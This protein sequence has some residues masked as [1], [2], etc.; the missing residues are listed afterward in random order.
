MIVAYTWFSRTRETM[1][2]DDIKQ[3][4]RTIEYRNIVKYN[5]INIQI[6]IILTSITPVLKSRTIVIFESPCFPIKSLLVT[7]FFP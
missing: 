5:V 3:M 2:R 1:H 4:T 7:Y 6:C